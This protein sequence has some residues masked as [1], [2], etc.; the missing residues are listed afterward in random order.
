VTP[1]PGRQRQ[2]GRSQNQ[3]E[4]AAKLLIDLG[5]NWCG[6]CRILAATMDLPR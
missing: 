3:G 4:G 5:G 1:T 6:D 2:G